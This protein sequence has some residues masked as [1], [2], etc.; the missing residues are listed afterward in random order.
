MAIWQDKN[1]GL[2]DDMNGAALSIP[3]WPENLTLLTDEQAQALQNPAP[4]TTDLALVA[5]SQRNA[6]LNQLQ[7]LYLRHKSQLDLGGSTTLTPVQFTDLVTLMEALRNV[8]EQPGFPS[9]V[10]WPVL[11]AWLSLPGA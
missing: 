1:G 2:H 11:P 5:R 10:T 8:P 6:Y 7:P 3:C 4:T 9:P